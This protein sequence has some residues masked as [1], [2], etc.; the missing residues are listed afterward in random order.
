MKKMKKMG[1]T[2]GMVQKQAMHPKKVVDGTEKPN[3]DFSMKTAPGKKL[4]PPAPSIP[5]KGK[6]VGPMGNVTKGR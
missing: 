2:M 5:S 3:C 1:A 4:T 6:A